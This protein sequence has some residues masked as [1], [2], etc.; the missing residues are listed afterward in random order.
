MIYFINSK[1]YKK[2]V[3]CHLMNEKNKRIIHTAYASVLSAMLLITALLFIISCIGIWKTGAMPFT[4]ESIGA[5]LMKLLIPIIITVLLSIGAPILYYALPVEKKHKTSVHP[6]DTAEILSKKI[7]LT[8]LNAARAE[9]VI[10]ERKKRSFL[11]LGGAL[12]LMLSLIYPIIYVLTP[13][14]FTGEDVNIDVLLGAL[15]MIIAFI[16]MAVYAIIAAYMCRTSYSTEAENLKAAIKEKSSVT[17]AERYSLPTEECKIKSF[18]SSLKS[19]Y[20]NHRKA[21]SIGIKC[22]VLGVAVLFIILGI[23]N[24]GMGDVLAKAVKICRECIG[25]G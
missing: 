16:P 9:R 12:L 10:A 11:K 5:A 24:G 20:R 1:I 17:D 14:N 21:F 6:E 19:F 22:S 25:L 2:E 15:H 4:R 13:A 8:D 18:I 3:R 7:A 23:F